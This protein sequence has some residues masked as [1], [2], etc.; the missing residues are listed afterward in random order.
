MGLVDGN[1]SCPKG[2]FHDGRKRRI[3][4]CSDGAAANR[5]SGIARK[6]IFAAEDSRS[7][8][9]LAPADS[10]TVG[11][12]LYFDSV[13][14]NS[15]QLLFL[16]IPFHCTGKAPNAG[17]YPPALSG[18]G[19]LGGHH[20]EITSYRGY[21]LFWRWYTNFHFCGGVGTASANS[22]TSF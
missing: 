15:M 21:D 5:L 8:A 12:L 2:I 1:S 4:G 17:I 6:A 10:E 3:V 11:R 14:S 20:S 9:A 22:R 16:C 13:L 18:T 7:T 19:N